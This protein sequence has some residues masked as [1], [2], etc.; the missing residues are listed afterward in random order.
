MDEDKPNDT[1]KN[2]SD[3]SA[4]SRSHLY[5]FIARFS[6]IPWNK[7]GGVWSPRSIVPGT[8]ITVLCPPFARSPI[9]TILISFESILRSERLSRI[10]HFKN[11]LQCPV[12][13]PACGVNLQ[14]CF[15]FA[16]GYM[17]GHVYL[18]SLAK[19]NTVENCQVKV[20]CDG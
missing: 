19:S 16:G 7:H 8:W 6:G 12:S 15:G 20:V 4:S 13:A 5:I 1:L 11:Q 14:P 10:S 2:F 17:E 3:A 9:S 18:P